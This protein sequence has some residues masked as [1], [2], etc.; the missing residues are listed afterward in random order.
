[1]KAVVTGP[2]LASKFVAALNE[3]GF[4]VTNGTPEALQQLGADVKAEP[5]ELTEVE[6]ASLLEDADVYIYG[7]LEVASGTALERAARLKLIAFLGTGWA[8]DG[9]VDKEAVNRLGIAVTNTPGAN[10]PSVAEVTIGLLLSLQRQIPYL[11]ANTKA[12][13]GRPTRLR[14]ISGRRLG[15]I[16]LGAIGGRVAAHARMG[17]SMDVV[18]SGPHRKTEAEQR[19]DVTYAPLEELLSSSDYVTLHCPAAKTRGL[20]GA[21]EIEL[22]KPGAFLINVASPEVVVAEPLIAALRDGRLAGAAFDGYYK[23][24]EATRDAFL[25]LPDDKLILLPRSAWLTD[26]SYERMA[27]MSLQNIRALLE[28]APPPNLVN[29]E[30]RHATANA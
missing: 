6:L 28:G 26:D 30:H 14:D 11:N 17:F 4:A 25:R 3:L 23:E 10:A 20:I 19:L 24:P 2:P 22:M 8:D 15:I 9:C 13:T 16:G 18:Y 5:R 27:S 21:K 7:G 12:G 1:M 29:P